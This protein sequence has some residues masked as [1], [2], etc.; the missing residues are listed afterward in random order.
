MYDVISRDCDSKKGNIIT[1]IH[2]HYMAIFSLRKSLN[3]WPRSHEFHNFGGGLLE[4]YH[5]FSLY[6]T[7]VEDFLCIFTIWPYLSRP[8]TWTPDP[9]A[10]NVTN[11]HV[12][13]SVT[14]LPI[15][16]TIRLVF[17]KYVWK[18]NRILSKILF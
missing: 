8:W 18:K 1:S 10:I 6:L 14:S 2:F 3:P 11:V 16:T 13:A 17:F 9:G 12:E 15:I 5:A 4:H 7:T